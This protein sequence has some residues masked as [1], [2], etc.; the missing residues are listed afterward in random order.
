M[1]VAW[2]PDVV[3]NCAAWTAV[4]ACEGDS[5][6]AHLANGFAVRWVAE[7]CDAIGARLVHISTDYVFD[8]TKSSPYGILSNL[9]FLYSLTNLPF[10]SLIIA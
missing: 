9:L 8:G 7:A 3:V 1:L 4:D 6:R 10:L 2:R 5:E